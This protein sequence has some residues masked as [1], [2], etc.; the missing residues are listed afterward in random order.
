[1][2]VTSNIAMQNPPVQRYDFHGSPKP[3][4]QQRGSRVADR[5][6]ELIEPFMTAGSFAAYPDTD[7][8]AKLR[9]AG[10][11][12]IHEANVRAKAASIQRAQDEARDEML[13]RLEEI[14]DQLERYE[15]VQHEH[16]ELVTKVQKLDEKISELVESGSTAQNELDAVDKSEASM[17]DLLALQERVS[18]SQKL[19]ESLVAEREQYVTRIEHLRL[20]LN[21]TTAEA[22]RAKVNDLRALVAD[23][24]AALARIEEEQEALRWE[25]TP[26]GP[27]VEGGAIWL[28]QFLQYCTVTYRGLMSER[29]SKI[30]KDIIAARD[31]N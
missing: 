15:N 27:D 7:E 30:M 2:T 29:G 12:L 17:T 21:S 28:Q 31:G 25:G 24:A 9:D 11:L 22:I 23:P 20:T 19:W 5:Y 26:L 3:R 16:D 6:Q 1:M 14:E 18:M 10:L 4:V 13:D 8:T